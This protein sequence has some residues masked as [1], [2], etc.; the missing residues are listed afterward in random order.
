MPEA[1]AGAPSAG[2]N[3]TPF[4]IGIAAFVILALIGGAIGLVMLLRGGEQAPE[5]PP[6]AEPAQTITPEP[7]PQPPPEPDPPGESEQPTR[8]DPEPSDTP[9][10][11]T[12][13]A[14]E[15]EVMH[16]LAP[17]FDEEAAMQELVAAFEAQTGIR[18]TL[19][20]EEFDLEDRL[21]LRVDTGDAP[22]V[23][24]FPNPDLLIEL[25]A[26]GD[27][28]ALD[29]MVDVD[30]LRAAMPEGLIE[31]STVDGTAYG[32]P[33]DLNIKSLVWYEPQAF[34]AGGYQPPD[35]YEEL[36]AL[37]AQMV[38]DG[39][40]PWCIHVESA[41]ATGWLLTDW[42]ED[43]VLRLHG[44]E[45]YHAWATGEVP[46]DSPEIRSTIEGYLDPVLFTDGFVA[47]GSVSI[48]RDSFMTAPTDLVD[49]RCL[50]H[51][52][53]AFLQGFFPP[54]TAIGQDVDVFALPPIAASDQGPSLLVAGTTAAALTANPAA[55]EF[56]T[57]LTGPEAGQLLSSAPSFVSPFRDF[58]VNLY[59]DPLQQRM[60][61]IL[62]AAQAARFDASDMMPRQVGAGAFWQEVSAYADRGGEDLDAMLRNI[63]AAW[64]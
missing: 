37:S 43:L 60:G 33:I 63:D 14:S 46:F 35:T 27:L 64:P 42:I 24:L 29:R 23:A 50:M 62:A 13:D 18:V 31:T 32:L 19:T 47:G 2:T 54:G 1:A 8:P 11:F 36:L 10:A 16:A 7:E 53:A 21:R 51:R 52:Q 39:M 28:V 57:F 58:D 20:G 12:G 59:S 61:T 6:V 26:Q 17:G 15:V 9:P 25:A 41:D 5:Q 38:A 44:G 55:A 30:A 49:G 40:T 56:L 45:V 22:D 3:L 34:A 4:F 48:T